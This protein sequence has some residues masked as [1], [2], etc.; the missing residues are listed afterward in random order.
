MV[1]H[2]LCS[3][4][5]QKELILENFNPKTILILSFNGPVDKRKKIYKVSTK[6]GIVFES[7]KIYEMMI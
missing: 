7:K 2:F 6:Q 1:I 4:K 5:L 3:M